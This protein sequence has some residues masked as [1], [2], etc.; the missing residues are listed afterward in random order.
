MVNGVLA[1]RSQSHA[2]RKSTRHARSPSFALTEVDD[3]NDVL[4]L[5]EADEEVIRLH[6]T[7][8]EALCVHVLQSAQKL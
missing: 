2:G 3:V 8:D 7:V 1:H 4:A 6:V 5:S